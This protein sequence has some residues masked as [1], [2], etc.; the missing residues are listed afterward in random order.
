[1]S[2]FTGP[3]GD[4]SRV[5]FTNTELVD[6]YAGNNAFS[7]GYNT[8][9]SLGVSSLVSSST[10]LLK[11]SGSA[12]SWVSISAGYAHSAAIKSDGTLWLWGGN[13]SYM[14]GDGTTIT[15]SSPVSIIVG[16]AWSSVSCGILSTAAI[17]TDGSLW[18]WGVDN[19]GQNGMNTTGVIKPSPSQTITGGNSWKSVSIGSLS[20][21]AIKTDGSL[22]SSGNNNNGQLSTG[23]LTNRSSFVQENSTANNWNAV[24]C[25]FSH[26]VALKSD[27]TM[28]FCGK[29]EMG[30][31]GDNSSSNTP[32]TAFFQSSPTTWK[33]AVAGFKNTAGIKYDGTLWACGYNIYGRLGLGLYN[34]VSSFTMVAGGGTTWKSVSIAANGFGQVGSVALKTDGTMWCA[35]S[36]LYGQGAGATPSP[37]FQLVSSAISFTSATMSQ[38]GF[39]LHAVGS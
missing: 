25:G 7:C 33:Y 22:W 4:L 30:Q 3:D 37:S 11:I 32:I 9:G 14:L 36:N 2:G 24:S 19:Y 23:N 39:R 18:T 31:F 1:M 8:D 28:W 34:N 12:Q 20:T 13:G 29:N 21:S 35:G 6:R 10:S 27:N 17:R 5:F 38:T 16:G 15:R 26:S